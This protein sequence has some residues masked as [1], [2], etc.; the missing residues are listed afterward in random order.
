MSSFISG[1]TRSQ[2]V[3]HYGVVVLIYTCISEVPGSNFGL[4]TGYPDFGCSGFP[5]SL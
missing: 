4:F 1:F 3:E 5:Q 2:A